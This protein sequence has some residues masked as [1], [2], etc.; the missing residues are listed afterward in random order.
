MAIWKRAKGIT[1]AANRAARWDDAGKLLARLTVGGLMLLHGIGKARHGV[2][3][4]AATL[5]AHHVPGVVAYGSYA[6]EL[7]A[8]AL[9][10]LGLGTRPAAAVLA[11]NMVVAVWLRHTADL[12][13]LSP[14]TGGL[15]AELPLLYLLGAVT[16]CLLG[17]G[18]YALSRGR[19]RWD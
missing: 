18:R 10:V 19:G 13:S 12:T 17:A 9:I 1:A 15:R 11:V 5:R 16:V 7:L 2:A 4:I 8:P 3:G 14:T 6:G